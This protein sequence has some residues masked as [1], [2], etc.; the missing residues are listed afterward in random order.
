VK[1]TDEMVAVF[2]DAWRAEDAK[3]DRAHGDRRRAGIQAVLA[4]L[5]PEPGT[6]ELAHN[7]VAAG[8][9]SLELLR[10]RAA[11][12]EADSAEQ[13]IRTRIAMQRR[14]PSST[15]GVLDPEAK[16][17]LTAI[18]NVR[19]ALSPWADPGWTSLNEAYDEKE[20]SNA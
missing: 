10:V 18:A 17:M 5:F 3:P 19:R 4:C 7:T 20:E 11:L 2:G 8:R 13:S 16:E 6:N 12:R 1:V 15:L 9:L 14:A